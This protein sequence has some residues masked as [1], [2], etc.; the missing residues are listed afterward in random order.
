MPP[1]RVVVSNSLLILAA[2]LLLGAA[3][4]SARASDKVSAQALIDQAAISARVDPDIS[5]RQ[6]ES[7]LELLRREPN[8]DL[9]IRARLLLCD[10][11]AERDR[12]AAEQQIAAATA[13]LPQAA[14]QGLRAGV[15]NCQGETLQTLGENIQASDL[16]Q[17]AT[18]IAAQTH[19][20]PM[21]AE[22]LFS[23]GYLRGL[24]G[25][26]AA[27][28]SE[29]RRAQAL[30]EQQQ[31]PQHAL[32]AL[33]SI[34]II[35]N[36][37]GDYAEAAHLH[38][39]TL[40]AQHKAGLK[41]EEVV[42][43]DNL[44]RAHDNLQQWDAARD[45]FAASLELSRQLSYIRGQAYALR[46]LATVANAQGNPNAAMKLLDRATEAQ[47][48]TP[49]AR[50]LAQIEL[51]RGIALHQLKRLK[52]SAAMLEQALVVFRQAD[53]LGE[54]TP[55]YDALAAVDAD[56]GDWRSAFDYRTLAQTT[57]TRLLRDQLDQRFETL[58]VEF[59]T[60]AKEQENELLTRENEAN[61]KALS[62]QLRASKLRTAVVVLTALLLAMLVWLAVH[63]RR[64]TLRL[65][66]LAMTD[67][68]TGVPNRRA[69]LALLARLLRR[70][71]TPT[72]ILIMDIDHFK[73]INDRHGHLIGDETLR[74]MTANLRE[75][76]AE[77][78][79]FGRLGG[80]EFAVVLPTT[81]LDQAIT[82]AER[83]RERVMRIDL[84]RWLGERR[85]TVSIGVA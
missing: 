33:G 8:P 49:D 52:E 65:R 58:K 78:A 2:A 44:G 51:A 62:Q 14:R 76:V 21:L 84:S 70:S 5:K 74:S 26:Y 12:A 69:V 28:L 80:E 85:I 63:Q 83:L 1:H 66:A 45:D 18:A 20:D 47:Q 31:M 34:A 72:S 64:S 79:L 25:E 23:S 37:M 29:L 57:A 42:T 60:A 41:R 81:D 53:S 30:F 38:E 50:L 77:P 15:L 61:Q 36:R 10:Y 75:A 19:D 4:P 68:L 11:Y 71:A 48:R 6:A 40:E 32:A 39:R 82:I 46:G 73:S 22:V 43:L 9:E 24:R 3:L 13:L 54:L 7:A 35:Y 27:G 56:L 17:Q 59:D 67:E 16:Y 55:T